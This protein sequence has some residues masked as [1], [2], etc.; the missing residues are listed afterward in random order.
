MQSKLN[1]KELKTDW[2]NSLHS[3]CSRLRFLISDLLEISRIN[4]KRLH[5]DLKECSVKEIIDRA[6][7]NFKFNYPDRA[8]DY[9]SNVAGAAVLIGDF[10]KLIQVFTNLLDNAAKFSPLDTKIFVKLRENHTSLIVQIEDHG[11]GIVSKDLPLVFEGY[12]KGEGTSH[13]GLGLGL[14]LVKSIV[15]HHQGSVFLRSVINK[16]TKIEVKL[17]KRRLRV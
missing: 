10:D 8:V 14:F 13:E 4:T 2:V 1:G 16:G 9:S 15:E 17:P 11:K 5:Y 6:I 12:Y 3:E 7:N